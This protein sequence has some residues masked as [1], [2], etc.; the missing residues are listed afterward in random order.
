MRET[1]GIVENVYV[2][3]LSNSLL[4]GLYSHIH[5]IKLRKNLKYSLCTSVLI[6]LNFF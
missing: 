1:I 3:W 5:T 6:K 2:P 4:F